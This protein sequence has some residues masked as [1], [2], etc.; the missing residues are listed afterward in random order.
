VSPYIPETQLVQQRQA[1]HENTKTTLSVANILA[2]A[3]V[4]TVSSQE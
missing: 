2:A 3:T 4:M 1:K